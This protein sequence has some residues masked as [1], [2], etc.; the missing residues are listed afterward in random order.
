MTNKLVPPEFHYCPLCGTPLASRTEEG[1]TRKFCPKDAWTYYPQPHLAVAG[2]ITR[3]FH[4]DMEVLLV[5]RGREP[6]K[7][8]WSIPA[9]FIEFGEHP[10]DTLTREIFE[11]TGLSVTGSVLLTIKRGLDDPRVPGVIVVFYSAKTAGD[12]LV[13]DHEENLDIQ[14]CPLA[15]LPKIAWA[16]HREVLESLK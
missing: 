10:E 4:G 3:Q 16:T 6:H 5:Q 1:M 2:V 11:E 12:I 13:N 14:W 9:G 8:L 15:N 7:G